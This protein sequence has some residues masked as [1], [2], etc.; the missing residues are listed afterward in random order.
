MPWEL[1]QL[2]PQAVGGTKFWGVV[3]VM[4]YVQNS[5]SKKPCSDLCALR[6]RPSRLAWA[7]LSVGSVL[8]SHTAAGS[9]RQVQREKVNTF[10][11]DRF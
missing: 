9:S 1:L 2:N 8:T 10:I 6:W 3:V 5:R 11:M 4:E 7:V